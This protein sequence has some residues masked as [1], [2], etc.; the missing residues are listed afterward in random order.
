M[1]D[2]L[3]ILVG[4]VAGF[5][6]TEH[7]YKQSRIFPKRRLLLS[8]WVRFVILGVVGVAVLKL[9]GIY[10]FLF[11]S[12]GFLISLFLNTLRRGIRIK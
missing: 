12:A 8:F 2:I 10:G 4:I 3:A 5:L 6:Y 1:G 9:L 11:F 7:I